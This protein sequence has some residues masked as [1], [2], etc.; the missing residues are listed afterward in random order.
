M[1]ERL[2]EQKLAIELYGFKYKPN[3]ESLNYDEWQILS[4]IC[5]LLN[6]VEQASRKVNFYFYILH[7]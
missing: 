6:P 4:E 3:Y 7:L 5:D 2:I 1:A